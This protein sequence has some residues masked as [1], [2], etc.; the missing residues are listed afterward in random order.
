MNRLLAYFKDRFLFYLF[1][2][3]VMGTFYLVL[4]LYDALIPAIN[5]ALLLCVFFIGIY[6]WIDF[7]R[8][9][10]VYKQLESI[11]RL[12]VFHMSDLP[13]SQGNIEKMYQELLYQ[14]D[15]A[16]RE[17]ENKHDN[18]YQDMLDYFTLWVHQ[19]KTPISALRLLI[20]SSQLSTQDLFMQVMRIEQYVEMTLHYMKIQHMSHDLK[21]KKYALKNILDEVIKKQRL[22]FINKKI[23]LQLEDIDLDIL[24]DEKWISFVLEQILSNALKY[25]KQGY[26]HIYVRDETLYIEDS[27][28]GIQA[29]D[30]PRLFE[31]GFTGYNGRSD[32]KASGLGLYLCKQVIDH[33]GYQMNIDSVLG[34]GTV[35]AI[36]FHVD[37][38]KVE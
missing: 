8:Y 26:I 38:L 21:I 7:Y 18:E 13:K 25:T 15:K 20:Q 5:Y 36:D 17:L 6:F 9:N 32:K 30:L 31:K 28:I 29:E 35:V 11:L 23:Q 2:F 27:G 10:R 14:V 4:Y 19:I 3:I 22:F 1:A 37:E 16:Y 33:L 34:K 24:T 12:D